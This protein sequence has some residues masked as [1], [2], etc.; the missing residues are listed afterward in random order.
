MK[1]PVDLKT[2]PSHM[3]MDY[4]R[5]NDNVKNNREL[6]DK[7]SGTGNELFSMC[8]R[9]SKCGGKGFLEKNLTK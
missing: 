8:R 5:Y 6:C 2:V 1:K 9:C 3:R 4:E 7:C